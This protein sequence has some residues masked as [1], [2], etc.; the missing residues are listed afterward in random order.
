[1]VLDI[2]RDSTF[3]QIVN[4]LSNGRFFPYAD[5]RPDYVPPL[6]YLRQGDAAM[7][8]YPSEATIPSSPTTPS[9]PTSAGPTLV[10]EA[11]TCKQIE[12][13]NQEAFDVHKPHREDAEKQLQTAVDPKKEVKEPY[14]WLVEFEENDPDRPMNWSSRKRLFVAAL[15]AILTFGVYFGSAIYT[16][17]VPGVMQEFGISQVA[18][19]SGLTLFVAAYGISPMILSPIQELPK[20]GRNPVYII[21]LAAFVIFQI[22]EI[23]ARNAATVLVFRFLSGFAGGPALATGGASMG[24]IFPPEHL[25]VAIGAWAIG[26]VSAP[27]LAPVVGSFAAQAENWRWPFL[28]LLW[29]SGATFLVLFFFLPETLESTVLVRRAERLRKLTGNPLLKAPAEVEAVEGESFLQ[30]LKVTTARAF[31]LSLEP[32]LAMCHLYIACVYGIF[33]LWFEAF[34]IVFQEM[35][36]FSLGMAGL[37]FLG[38]VVTAALTFTFYVLY[39]KWHIQPRLDRNPDT[40]VEVRLELGVMAGPLV[41]ISLLIFGWTAGRGHWM[42]PVIGAALYLPPVFLLFQ[43]C[44]MYCAQSYPIYAASI[45]AGNDLFR[46]VVAS[47]FPLFGEKYFHALGVGPGC[48]ILAGV[49]ALMVPALYVI[50]KMGPRLRARSRFAEA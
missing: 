39:Q 44:L 45:L 13:S 3:G 38:F 24:D 12:A 46:S 8:S 7:S 35:Y 47:L 48:T 11:G 42:G 10:D 25:A 6:H 16:P 34:P 37:P 20:V 36:G 40:P 9:A 30:S 23:L 43:S 2:V 41:P 15:I 50:M 49:S 27:T 5:Q 18:G 22:P 14:P 26:A 21:G 28:E 17:S 32:S 29:L 31:R 33:Y 19:I 4:R 1:M